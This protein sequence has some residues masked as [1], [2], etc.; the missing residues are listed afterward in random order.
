MAFV[1][2]GRVHLADE[3]LLP[4]DLAFFDYRWDEHRVGRSHRRLIDKWQLVGYKTTY[5][6]VYDARRRLAEAQ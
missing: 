1:P 5:D 4:E 6:H 3:A 2:R